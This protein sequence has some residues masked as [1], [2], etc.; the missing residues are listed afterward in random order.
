MERDAKKKL[1]DYLPGHP[2]LN[3]ATVG[4]E[5]TPLAHTVA[6]FND[7]GVVYIATDK[8]SRKA[9]NM[10]ANSSVAF[11][12]DEDQAAPPT[13]QGIQMRGTAMLVTDGA[14]LGRVQQ[15]M[16]AKYP[17]MKDM[18]P[19]PNYVVFRITPVEGYFLDNTMGYG[20]RDLVRF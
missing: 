3:L 10:M 14:E 20:Y 7:G 1:I 11:T 2:Y 16:M 9:K 8:T 15:G 12:V 18:P 6:Y 5:G 4:P 19:N 17:A 13:M